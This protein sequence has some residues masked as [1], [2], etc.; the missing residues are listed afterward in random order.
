MAY[1][2]NKKGNKVELTATRHA[3]SR[4]FERYRKAFPDK[5]LTTEDIIPTFDR[6]FSKSRRVKKFNRWEKAR[7]KKHGKDSMFFRT[8]GLTFVVQ[9]ATIRTVEISD[10]DK[11]YLNKM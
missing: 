6:M 8:N 4:F 11:R 3:Y 1:Y 2:T 5:N 7:L 9:N 10:K